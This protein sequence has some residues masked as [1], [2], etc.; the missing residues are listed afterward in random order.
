MSDCGFS[1]AVNGK[2]FT[3]DLSKLCREANDEYAFLDSEQRAVSLNVCS[4]TSTA[5][6]PPWDT[7]TSRGAIVQQW[8]DE[9]YGPCTCI[10]GDTGTFACCTGYC[11]ILG[12]VNDSP[13]AWA[14]QMSADPMAGVSLTYGAA[15]LPPDASNRCP[16]NAPRRV[17][18][19]IACDPHGRVDVM[20]VKGMSE[21][22]TCSYQVSATSG[23]ACPVG[24]L[25]PSG[26][27]SSLSPQSLYTVIFVSIA[28][29][30]ALMIASCC[31]CIH[32]R[33]KYGGCT[34]IARTC[35]HCVCSKCACCRSEREEIV[36][37]VPA[38]RT[39][40]AFAPVP[41]A[42]AAPQPPTDVQP[43]A[44]EAS[45]A[46]EPEQVLHAAFV[47]EVEPVV[48]PLEVL[49][50]STDAAPALTISPVAA[51]EETVVLTQDSDPV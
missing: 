5:C 44:S 28:A 23:A 2:M 26:G 33:H 38:L 29:G 24:T 40:P 8:E 20:K 1:A 13:A 9:P 7:Y 45:A 15:F 3:W 42:L 51:A 10:D 32:L 21:P 35:V 22:S 49:V 27:G 34:G 16:Q 39:T 47:S 30:L 37:E 31:S 19:L 6:I 48:P 4:N 46:V 17:T 25:I 50:T 12:L 14:M 36:D 41:I 43:P 11:A 18:L